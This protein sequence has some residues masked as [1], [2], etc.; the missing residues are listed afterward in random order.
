M[1]LQE[2][3]RQV[4]DTCYSGIYSSHTYAGLQTKILSVWRGCGKLVTGNCNLIN[5]RSINLNNKMCEGGD[6]GTPAL[7]SLLSLTK[8][9][10]DLYF[11]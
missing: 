1:A 8:I 9:V 6:G 2:A 3:S 5:W 11:G 4:G 7:A 10:A